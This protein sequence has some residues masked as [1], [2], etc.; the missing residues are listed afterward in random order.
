MEEPGHGRRLARST[1]I[2]SAATGLSRVLGLVR[3]MVA[4]YYFGVTGQINAFTVAFQI[5]NLIRALLGVPTMTGWLAIDNTAVSHFRQV[6]G[7]TVAAWIN[8]VGHL[9]ADQRSE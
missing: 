7:L 4:A 5:P 1:A 6:E 2:F 3:E 8:R 9:R